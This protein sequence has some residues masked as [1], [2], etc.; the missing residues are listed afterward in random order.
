MKK[1]RR[2]KM[3]MKLPARYKTITRLVLRQRTTVLSP[4]RRKMKKRMRTN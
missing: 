2:P 3:M 1:K 4:K